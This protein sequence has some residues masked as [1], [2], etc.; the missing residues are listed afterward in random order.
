MSIENFNPDGCSL[1][2]GNFIGLPFDEENSK[3]VFLPIP[4]EVTVS[5]SAGT[6]RAAENILNASYQL[7]LYDADVKD[8]WRKGIFMS[9]ADE[10]V[11]IRSDFY[12]EK[13]ERYI[14]FIENQGD[15]NSN[16]EMKAILDEINIACGEL[17]DWVYQ[18]TKDLLNRG[19]YVGLIGGDHSTPLGY[20]RALAE[21]HES[22]GILH[23]DAHFDLRDAYE[24]FTYSHASIFYNALKLKQ[25]EKIV[26]IG[27]R[28]YAASEVE[29]VANSNNRVEVF[30][31]HEIQH[32][33]LDG[34]SFASICDAMID[35]L[36][37]KVY[38]SFDIDGLNPNLC[39]STGTPVPG[40]FEYQQIIY[41]F[42]K[43]KE[44]GR[45]VIGFDL[46]E[47][48]IESEWDGNVAA[49]LLYKMANLFGC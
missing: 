45:Q 8:A 14:E 13:A 3:I 6:A 19:K 31:D 10:G 34:N 38:I 11:L 7:D 36:P 37:Q 9:P 24:G 42:K 40:G 32:S 33:L 44:S 21:R 47:V 26:T 12:R 41:L 43:L 30:Y 20:Y 27:I 17:Q 18:Q 35:K 22:F 15:V 16:P 2:N 49:R 29:L 28:D 48:G 39:P 4:W 25:V 23:I 46:V 1:A 5:Y